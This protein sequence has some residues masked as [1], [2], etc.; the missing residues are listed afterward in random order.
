MVLPDR[1]GPA[2][3]VELCGWL[4]ALTLVSYRLTLIRQFDTG[5]HLVDSRM[6][7][8]GRELGPNAIEAFTE[9]KN[10]FISTQ[11]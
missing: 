7:G 5:L 2:M 8:I 6:S 11:D 4:E 9:T 10:V 1:F 3:L